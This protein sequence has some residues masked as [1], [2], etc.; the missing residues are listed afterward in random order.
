MDEPCLCDL[1][2]IE[3][4]SKMTPYPMHRVVLFSPSFFDRPHARTANSLKVVAGPKDMQWAFTNFLE[5]FDV[6]FWS[7]EI[8]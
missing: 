5:K 7:N 8:S 3:V 1:Q 2:D 6:F 4:N